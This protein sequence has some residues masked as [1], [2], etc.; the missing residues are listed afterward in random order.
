MT[1]VFPQTRSENAGDRFGFSLFIAIA[2]HALVI[3]GIGFKLMQQQPTPTTLEITLAQH[4]STKTPKDA[5]FLAQ[6]DQQGSGEHQ[7]SLK[8]TSR[9]QALI[10]DNQIQQLTAPTAQQQQQNQHSTAVVLTTL[11]TASDHSNNVEEQ[12]EQTHNPSTLLLSPAALQQIASLKSNLDDLVQQRSKM[13]KIRR[14]TSANTKAAEEAAYLH[15]WIGHIEAIGNSN[16]PEEAQRGK[17]Y[18]DLR[19]VVT[20]LPNGSVDNVEILRSSGQRVLDQA[21]MRIV[22]MASPFSPLPP[23]M[24]QWDKLEIIRT[25]RF[26]QG[27]TLHTD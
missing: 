5:D 22:R 4:Q 15:Y 21:A 8:L 3:F 26:E 24:K 2:A 10:A 18:G 25:W 27:H 9:Q 23:E 11:A 20:I 19:L 1:T 16:Y 12:V 17:I 7:Q 6:F 13:P 14:I